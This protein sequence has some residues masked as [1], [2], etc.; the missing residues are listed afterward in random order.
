MVQGYD[1]NSNLSLVPGIVGLALEVPDKVEGRWV[2][3]PP[4]DEAVSQRDVDR[5]AIRAQ[6]GQ[7]PSNGFNDF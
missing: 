6:F 2:R 1:R 5:R 3:L 7:G 4:C